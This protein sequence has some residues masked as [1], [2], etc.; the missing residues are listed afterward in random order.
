MK[1]D[2]RLL[3]DARSADPERRGAAVDALLA[4]GPEGIPIVVESL[5]SA[6]PNRWLVAE[7]MVLHGA[8]LAPVF[9]DLLQND[10][11]GETRILS[12]LALYTL[13]EPDG[14]DVLL[15]AIRSGSEWELVAVSKLAGARSEG[16]C[17]A[18]LDRLRTIPA[19]RENEAT[20]ARLL[21]VLIDDGREIPPQLRWRFSRLESPFWVAP[22]LEGR[23]GGSALDRSRRPARRIV[24]TVGLAIAGLVVLALG[25]DALVGVSQP[26]F[27]AGAAEGVLRTLDEAGKL[28]ESRLVVIDDGGVLW[29]QS[30]HH[31]R[32]WYH[33]LL[34][35]PDVELVRSG[36]TRAYRAVPLDTPE[37]E[38]RIEQLLK[39]RAGAFRYYLIR[40]LLLFADVKPVRLDPRG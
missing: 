12:A 35:N 25:I 29:I 33:R 4:L 1:V 3:L 38:A 31:F 32:G 16:L 28:H 5:R 39:Q 18:V 37:T 20:I 8:S 7:R 17:A 40:T 23:G 26:A 15:D 13:G 14:E 10:A 19:V 21:Q 9:R 22:Q 30:A 6:G 34:R 36:E 11:D 24:R 2:A 27:E